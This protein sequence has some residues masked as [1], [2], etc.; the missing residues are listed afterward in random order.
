[1]KH[2]WNVVKFTCGLMDDSSVLIKRVCEAF[3][4]IMKN[5]TFVW[6]DK[7]FQFLYNYTYLA[8]L[9]HE[10]SPTS[11][12][13]FRNNVIC[14]MKDRNS[15]L[16]E[17]SQSYY[18]YGT[19]CFENYQTEPGLVMDLQEVRKK[20]TKPC[21]VFIREP[22]NSP[23]F[24][25]TAQ[26]SI[27]RIK[28]SLKY[29]RVDGAKLGNLFFGMT[30]RQM[31]MPSE[32]PSG[33]IFGMTGRQMEMPSEQPSGF[34]RVLDF[35]DKAVVRFT[36][37]DFRWNNLKLIVDS[38]KHCRTLHSFELAYC[39]KVD[40]NLICHLGQNKDLCS[41]TVCDIHRGLSLDVRE[42]L[43]EQIKLLGSL[44]HL[45]I[46]DM[47]FDIAS[48]RS[49][50]LT[51]VSLCCC[52]IECTEGLAL[53][54]HLA[55]CPVQKLDLDDNH[56]SE[57]FKKLCKLPDISYP[58]LRS[59]SL[60]R[61]RAYRSDLRGIVQLLRDDKMPAIQEVMVTEDEFSKPTLLEFEE[62]C[63][64]YRKSQ[65]RVVRSDRG[66]PLLLFAQ[67]KSTWFKD[68]DTD[69]DTDP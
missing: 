68:D 28:Q 40:E 17:N 52:G 5:T 1:M 20:S 15:V 61:T 32:Q 39:K 59:M 19:D 37:C 45:I 35:A 66:R 63:R 56:L 60:V 31:E 51:E 49:T 23:H 38:I 25:Y 53:M 3:V 7:S 67:S 27:S 58:Y 48:V 57:M 2:Q 26:C 54:K 30:G 8:D 65:C 55:K 14:C 22:T 12:N 43:F 64:R 41:L 44:T 18:F 42:K 10:K 50:S 34:H 62:S 24:M 46:H 21:A 36:A 33:F 29:L 6:Y 9:H 13:P 69:D 47:D 4:D 11:L 16:R